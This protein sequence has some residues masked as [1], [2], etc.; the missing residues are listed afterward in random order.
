MRKE[1]DGR[2][3]KGL[4]IGGEGIVDAERV[5]GALSRS[6]AAAETD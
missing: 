5:D 1:S 4:L 3:I 6:D 2:F